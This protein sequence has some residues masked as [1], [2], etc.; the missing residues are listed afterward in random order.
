MKR[1]VGEEPDDD[2]MEDISVDR[3]NQ[4]YAGGEVYK[5]DT[6]DLCNLVP[7]DGNLRQ[8]KSCW[9]YVCRDCFGS[10]GRC[11]DCEAI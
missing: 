4:L 10:A 8:C 7:E 1:P 3:L 11:V 9:Y 5:D 6:C 2:E